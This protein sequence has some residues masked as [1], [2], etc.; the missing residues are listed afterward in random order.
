MSPPS[1]RVPPRRSP[2]SQA[3]G[4]EGSPDPTERKKGGCRFARGRKTQ[5]S[6]AL[7]VSRR[8]PRPS[9]ARPLGFRL[10]I[11]PCGWTSHAK[12]EPRLGLQRLGLSTARGSGAPHR[13]TPPTHTP[14]GPVQ[15]CGAG[16]PRRRYPGPG[17][18]GKVRPGAHERATSSTTVPKR[19]VRMS[20]WLRDRALQ[21]AAAGAI[22]TWAAIAGVRA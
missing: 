16:V 7:R 22:V 21:V 8:P 15:L 4:L 5:I 12:A 2:P 20:R 3:G 1:E 18:P 14:P 11:C 9:A 19:W 13:R 17:A 6:T 10:L